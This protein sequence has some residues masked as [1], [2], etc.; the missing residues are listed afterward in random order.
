M[1]AVVVD[2]TPEAPAFNY[3]CLEFFSHKILNLI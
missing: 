2:L 1:K 3:A